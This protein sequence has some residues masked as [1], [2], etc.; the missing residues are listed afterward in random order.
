MAETNIF[1]WAIITSECMVFSICLCWQMVGPGKGS[2]LDS[3]YLPGLSFPTWHLTRN[4]MAHLLVLFICFSQRTPYSGILVFTVASLPLSAL[5]EN[6]WILASPNRDLP[7][8]S[9]GLS[10]AII[11]PHVA[12]STFVEEVAELWNSIRNPNKVYLALWILKSL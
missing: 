6:I 8:G 12:L 1:T 11:W 3:K 2:S 7:W 10:S 9:I 4:S 5:Q